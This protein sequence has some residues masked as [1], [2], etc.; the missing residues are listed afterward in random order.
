ME[1]LQ[2]S[3]CVV[4]SKLLPKR[5]SKEPPS[6][7]RLLNVCPAMRNLQ[8]STL[9]IFI[10]HLCLITPTINRFFALY[11]LRISSRVGWD[12]CLL[13]FKLTPLGP[14]V[15]HLVKKPSFCSWRIKSFEKRAKKTHCPQ[16]ECYVLKAPT[17]DL[18]QVL[19]RT[20]APKGDT[21]LQMWPHKC[22]KWITSGKLIWLIKSIF[23][24]Q[25]PSYS[26]CC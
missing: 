21:V 24:T 4:W 25:C 9:N 1:S 19:A 15:F 23:H 13:S 20:G 26:P 12:C 2:L 8:R 16:S 7:I 11:L 3:L 14:V 10:G 18:T 6:W 17:A 5:V 22:I